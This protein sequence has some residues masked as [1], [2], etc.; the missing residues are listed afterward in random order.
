MDP[1]WTAESKNDQIILG[2]LE[3][4]QGEHGQQDKSEKER[5]KLLKKLFSN[6]VVSNLNAFFN[7]SYQLLKAP[8]HISPVMKLVTP[9]QTCWTSSGSMCIPVRVFLTF[10]NK[11][12]SA[13]ARSGL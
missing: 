8:I 4:I 5:T 11:K 3:S 1:K 12:K 10:G 6:I 2:I 13:G 9:S 7:S